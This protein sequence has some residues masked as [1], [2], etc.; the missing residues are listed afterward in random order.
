MIACCELTR[1]SVRKEARSRPGGTAGA[2]QNLTKREGVKGL[3]YTTRVVRKDK[4]KEDGYW[5][6]NG[7]KY[8]RALE[9]SQH[10]VFISRSNN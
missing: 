9:I 2:V 10:C 4:G 7:K 6:R 8:I 1:S 3:V 5:E